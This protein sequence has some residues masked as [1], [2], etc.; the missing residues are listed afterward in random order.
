M[1][2]YVELD[3]QSSFTG[4]KNVIKFLPK[5]MQAAAEAEVEATDPGASEVILPS[6]M[7][8][9]DAKQRADL[10][11]R[12]R[13]AKTKTES[14]LMAK[15]KGAFT[16]GIQK[17]GDIMYQYSGY[18]GGYGAS[19]Q[20]TLLTA[21]LNAL[22]AGAGAAAEQLNPAAVVAAKAKAEEEDKMAK[23]KMVGGAALILGLGYYFFVKKKAPSLRRKKRKKRR[24]KR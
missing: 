14:G 22:K 13:S 21:G 18:D 5:E 8:P 24:K 1:A 23:I 19:P 20:D 9:G 10:L 17:Q 12:A 4:D 7:S 2:S 6:Q 11:A 16:R 3:K 15:L